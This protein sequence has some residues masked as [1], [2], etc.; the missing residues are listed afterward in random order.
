[1]KRR[2]VIKILEKNGFVLARNGG[3]HDVYFNSVTLITIP[4][5]RHNEIEDVIAKKIFKQAGIQ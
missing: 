3:N 1:M 2:D 4:L 5:K